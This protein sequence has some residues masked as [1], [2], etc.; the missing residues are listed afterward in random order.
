LKT[1]QGSIDEMDAGETYV[2]K[3]VIY[4]RKMFMKSTSG[5]HLVFTSQ[6]VGYELQNND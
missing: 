4:A 1:L 3:V 2:L 6:P 5:I